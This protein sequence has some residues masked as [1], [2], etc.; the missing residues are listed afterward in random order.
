MHELLTAVKL[1]LKNLYSNAGRTIL[2]LSGIVIGVVSIIMVLSLGA[3]VKNFIVMQ[4]ES[5]GTDIIEVEVKTPKTSKTST[6]NVAGMLGGAPVTT[7]KLDDAEAVAKKP[8]IG[9]WYAGVMGQQVVSYKSKNKQTFIMGVTE[10]LLEA[11][12]KAEIEF[13]KMFSRE[14]A[15][16]LKQ[17]VILGSEVKKKFFQDEEAVG[18]NIKIKGESYRVVGVLKERGIAGFFNFDDLIYM[19]LQTLQKKIM[20]ID[21]IQF[22]IFK[23][24]DKN[25]L[26]LTVLEATQ[27]MRERHDIENPDDDDFAVNSITEATEILDKA[28]VIIN[29]L[30]LALTSISLIVGGVGIMNV[31]YVA[32]TERTPEI[33]LRKAVGAR[34]IDILRQFLFEAL[35]ITFLGGALGIIIGVLAAIGAEY[36]ASRLG[37]FLEFKVTFQSILISLGFSALVG[38]LFG[39]YPARKAS[40][41]VPMEALRKE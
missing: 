18:K 33:G 4:V 38:I 37:Y 30:L 22:S 39:F 32:V 15:E 25:R 24:D 35:F 41:L 13:G 34:G 36:I 10:G 12:K 6:Q 14:D 1:A 20:G 21:Y 28:F 40:K 29:I 3:G 27:T 8:N 17:V 16:D 5:F 7:L 9:A 2:S 26:E 31:M 23:L 19:P 11:D